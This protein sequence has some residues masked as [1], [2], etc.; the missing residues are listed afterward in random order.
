MPR[1]GWTAPFESAF[2]GCMSTI[3]RSIPGTMRTYAP[4]AGS[5][6]FGQMPKPM[7]ADD[8]CRCHEAVQASR[9]RIDA[10]AQGTVRVTGAARTALVSC[11]SLD[12]E[13]NAANLFRDR[14][15]SLRPPLDAHDDEAATVTRMAVMSP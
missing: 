15:T 5:R 11:A 6:P 3:R 2:N 10:A 7:F 14:L 4:F 9:E 13:G 12:W 1:S 8:G